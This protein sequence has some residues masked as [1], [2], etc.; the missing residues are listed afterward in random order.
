MT[1][2]LDTLSRKAAARRN[3]LEELRRLKAS[4]TDESNVRLVVV[5]GIAIDLDICVVG[6][7][8][9]GGMRITYGHPG[10]R[11]WRGVRPDGSINQLTLFAQSIIE[12]AA[13]LQ[14]TVDLE[15]LEAEN[16]SRSQVLADEIRAKHGSSVRYIVTSTKRAPDK[17]ELNI[18][19]SIPVDVA[20]KML[21]EIRRKDPDFNVGLN[22]AR[23][24][25]PDLADATVGVYATHQVSLLAK[26]RMNLGTVLTISPPFNGRYTA[27]LL[28]DG[29]PHPQKVPWFEGG[30][31]LANGH[32]DVIKG[33]YDDFGIEVDCVVM[34]DAAGRPSES[35]LVS[36][37]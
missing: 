26:Y 19:E 4:I 16:R 31:S 17:V 6:R 7:A 22:V 2:M 13:E 37:E 3:L 18:R 10:G 11:R 34:L 5:N 23:V 9:S 21:Q 24:V 8:R 20:L 30:V 35:S 36:R 1:K 29:Q 15:A 25:A 33:L 27:A 28:L 12:Y 14:A 32:C